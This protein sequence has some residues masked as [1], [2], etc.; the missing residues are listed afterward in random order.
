MAEAQNFVSVLH[1]NCSGRQKTMVRL[2][3]PSGRH[4]GQGSGRR[5]TRVGVKFNA[6]FVAIIVASKQANG[7]CSQETIRICE[8][9]ISLAI[10]IHRQA[11]KW[12]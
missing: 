12:N 3:A 9:R 1:S 8:A 5:H 10:L 11:A 6:T 7:S 4:N 2:I